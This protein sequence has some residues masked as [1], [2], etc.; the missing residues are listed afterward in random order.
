VPDA[1]WPMLVENATFEAMKRDGD[2]LLPETAMIFEGG[3]QTFINKGTNDR[4]RDVLTSAEIAQYEA[5]V[6]KHANE[7]AEVVRQA[8]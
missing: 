1:K 4:W 5:V 2:L 6:S 3:S 7:L 8:V